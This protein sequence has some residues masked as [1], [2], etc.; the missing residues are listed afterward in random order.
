VLLADFDVRALRVTKNGHPSH[1][2]YLPANLTAQAYQV[3]L[4]FDAREV[5]Y[6]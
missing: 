4:A 6:E 1:P 5:G 2:L 3:G